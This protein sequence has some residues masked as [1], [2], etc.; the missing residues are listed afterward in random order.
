MSQELHPKGPEGRECTLCPVCGVN[1]LLLYSNI[2]ADELDDGT[3]TAAWRYTYQVR[4]ECCTFELRNELGN[5]RGHNLA[6]ND[7]W[8][9]K[10][11]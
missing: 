1:A 10:E 6:I 5:P 7:Y 2:D 9:C 11:L 8:I 4:C 3:C